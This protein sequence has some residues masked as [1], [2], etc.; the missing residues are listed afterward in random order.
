MWRHYLSMGVRGILRHRLY[1]VINIAG[2]AVGLTCIIFVVLFVRD[3]L[4]YDT[5]VPDSRNVY[6]VELTVDVPNRGPLP[7]AV[8]PY[9]MPQ[10]MRDQIP[11]V[12]A[13]TRLFS[14]PLTLTSGDRQILQRVDVVDPGFFEMI[15]LPLLEGDPGAVFR[16]PESVVLT[17]SAAKAYFGAADPIGRTLTAPAGNCSTPGAACPDVSLRVTG[18]V[19]DLP[20]NTQLVGDA[21]IPTTSLANFVVQNTREDWFQESGWGYVRLAPGTSPARVAAAMAPI[22][23]QVVTPILLKYTGL[24]IQGSRVYHAHLTPFT[25]VHLASSHWQFNLQPGGSWS[26]VYGVI[27]IGVLTL[28]V[29]CVNFMNL[30][31]ARATLRAREIALRKLLG[32]GRRQL[33]LQF[34]GEA[35]LVALLSLML[36]LAL[37]EI[38]LPL[39]DKFLQRPLALHY[40]GDLRLLLMLAGVAVAT[41][42]I[43]GSYPALVLSGLRPIGGLRAGDAAPQRSGRLRNALVVLQFSVS[44]AM[45]IA[46]GVVFRQI[47]YARAMDLGFQHSS[48]LVIDSSPLTGEKQEAFADALRADPGVAAVGLSDFVPFTTGQAVSAIQV[49]GQPGLLTINT[50]VIDPGYSGV[51]DIPLIAGRL[52]SADRGAD[53]LHSMAILSSGDPLNEGRNILINAAAARHLGF[54]P[55]EA[56]GKTIIYNHNH[57]RIVG[58]LADAKLQGAR[59]PVVPMIYIYV[60][61]FAMSF[62][63]RLRPGRIPQ[64]LKFIDRTW[65]AF[66][67]TLAIHRWFLDSSY[68]DLYSVDER[69]G[70]MLGVFVIVAVLIGCLGLYGL[71]VFTAERRTK[72][73]GIRKVSGART[74]DIVGLMLWRISVPVLVAN[75]IAWPV[76]YA[77]LRQWLDGYAYRITLSP[78]YFLAAALTALLVAWITVYGNTLRLARVSP[79]HAL[80]YE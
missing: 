6:R 24:N 48:V 15:R 21:F 18:V 72:E 34:L 59:Q 37:A 45:T 49:P 36:A 25:Q 67:P 31:T 9:P 44:V 19:R 4:S 8:I 69:E 26:T 71:A 58:V 1:G 51:Y 40:T 76:A 62:S 79:V 35:V 47:S 53:R 80:R 39:F 57:V 10:A 61:D 11:G 7:M 43:S 68:Q 29:A 64:T 42:L 74:A 33:I 17:E 56:V 54:S 38:L 12:T 30:T 41:G 55:N 14:Q 5:W 3:E 65:H 66:E 75:L 60:P 32:A 13:M 50:T 28:L 70:T 16:Q 77:Y 22:F 20:H 46:A 78:V 27:I 23:D 63:V 2:L 52:L 73:I